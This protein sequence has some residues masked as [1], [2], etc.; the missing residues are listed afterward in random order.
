MAMSGPTLLPHHARNA[1]SVQP[2][3]D[4]SQPRSRYKTTGTNPPPI[5]INLN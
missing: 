2:T 3:N 1:P 5:S 4:R